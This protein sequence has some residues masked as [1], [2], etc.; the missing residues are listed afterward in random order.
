VSELG[1]KLITEP[2]VECLLCGGRRHRSVFDEHGIAIVRCRD[3]GHVSSSYAGERHYDGFWGDEVGEDEHTYWRK[4]RASTYR[5]FLDRFVAGKGGRLLDMGCG[6]GF[7]LQE[8]RDYPDWQSYGC[9]ISPA[10]V[11]YARER[12]S[13]ANVVCARL[14]E[15]PLPEASFDIITMW[16]VLD[17]LLAPDPVLRRCHALLKDDGFC[18]IRTPNIAMHLPRAR[19][20]KLVWGIRPG[21]S[22]LQARDHMHH[23]STSSARRLLERNGFTRIQFVHL[24]PVA[25]VARSD[26]ASARAMRA[27][28][29]HAVRAL[30]VC[31]GG[32]LNFDNLF[33]VAR[34]GSDGSRDDR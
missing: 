5:H 32:R 16:D 15:A 4:A 28:W 30:A 7:F 13:L 10:A 27:V 33:I 23:Y 12:L 19:V 31:S 25:S 22:Y 1:P 2:R 29:F 14:E 6:L 11:R 21:V 17:H 8:M 9:E 34:K 24:R 20:N 18:F 26:S 3:C